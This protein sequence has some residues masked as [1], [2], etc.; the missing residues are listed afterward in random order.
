MQQASISDVSIISVIDYIESILKALYLY[1]TIVMNKHD[2]YVK[3]IC[4]ICNVIVVNQ[5]RNP[6]IPALSG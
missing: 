2:I 4:V 5:P 1:N 6:R 3:T